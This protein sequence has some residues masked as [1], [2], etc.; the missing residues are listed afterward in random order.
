[1]LH[2]KGWC[3]VISRSDT[4]H[5]GQR[6]YYWFHQTRESCFSWSESPLDAFWQT[7]SRL[8]C[9]IYW[10]VA[11]SSRISL[12]GSKLLPFKNNGGHCVLGDLQCCRNVFIPFPRYVPLHNLVSELYGQF[13]R[14]HGLVF[15]LTLYRQV[16]AFPNHVQSIEFSTGGVQSSCR[17]ISRMINGN[18]MHMSSISSHIAK[19]LNIYVNKVFQFLLFLINLE[20]S[21]T[22]FA[23]SLWVMVW[24]AEDVFI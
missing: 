10:G 19:G 3:Q 17:N 11:A 15:A 16:C 22:F 5:S 14:H 4:W 1:M 18:R 20:K 7:P 24:I 8:S 21:Q 13:F 23:L 9:S 2:C 12:G 6:F